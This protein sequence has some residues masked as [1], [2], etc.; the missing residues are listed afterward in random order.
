MQTFGPGVN[1]HKNGFKLHLDI[2]TNEISSKTWWGG[3]ISKNGNIHIIF[4]I[5]GIDDRS[6]LIRLA[7]CGCGSIWSPYHMDLDSIS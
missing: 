6:I 1:F 3:E 7:I 2:C 5:K 4:K